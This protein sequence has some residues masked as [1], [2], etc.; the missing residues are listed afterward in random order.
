MK[1]KKEFK[2]TLTVV[3]GRIYRHRILKNLAPK[4][5]A[6][7]LSLTPEAYRN[8]ERG[9]TDPSFTTL[10]SIS[11]ILGINCSDLINDL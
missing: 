6:P 8:I 4:E 9:V 1:S 11:K 7:L 10:L 3:G 5:I 2:S